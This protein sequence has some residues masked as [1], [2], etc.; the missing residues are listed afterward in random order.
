MTRA[1]AADTFE[2]TFTYLVDTGEKPVTYT[3]LPEQE[4]ENPGTYETRSHTVTDARPMADTLD[5]D[6]EGFALAPHETRVTDFYDEDQL[7][8]I[9]KPELERL[10]MEQTGAK[11][12]V[13]FDLT[14]RAQD[15]DIQ[16]ARGVRSPVKRVHND[17]TERSAPRRVRDLMPAD[18][19]EDLL[20][21]RFAII[22]VWR[23]MFGPLESK[24]LALLDA[25]SIAPDDLIATER[26]S[27]DRIGEVQHVTFNPDHRWYYFPRQ[28]LNETVLIK[29]YDSELDG[30]ARFAA[31]TAIDDPNTPA[32]A[33]PRES[34]EARTF[35]FF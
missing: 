11:R 22:N 3:N 26:R 34:I 19:A 14:L 24:P 30:R 28:L 5:L 33:R 10:V 16:K 1:E 6:R 9:Y 15:E 20:T 35:V 21:R 12:V 18:E 25:R 29:C 23:P 4:K 27:K 17:Y 31:H 32:N 8:N 7:E 2:T 13:V